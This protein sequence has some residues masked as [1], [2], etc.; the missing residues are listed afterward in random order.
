MSP[1]AVS[2][3]RS[4]AASAPARPA[5]RSI[6]KYIAPADSRVRRARVHRLIARNNN[7]RAR[8]RS[9]QLHFDPISAR[10][11]CAACL[12]EFF[13]ARTLTQRYFNSSVACGINHSVG[14]CFFYG[15]TELLQ[16]DDEGR[17]N[18]QCKFIACKYLVACK[19][20]TRI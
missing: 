2:R 17:N 4:A 5:D 14:F 15:K 7:G 13:H 12:F 11:P 19:L 10:P 1:A 8:R 16:A 9:R 3:A 18:L 6:G 20:A